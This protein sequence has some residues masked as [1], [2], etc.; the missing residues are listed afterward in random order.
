LDKEVFNCTAIPY[1]RINNHGHIGN[2]L[3]KFRNIL[4]R[5]SVKSEIDTRNRNSY[6]L[7]PSSLVTVNM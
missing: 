5:I 2:S 4:L 3:D 7:N 1:C 6:A